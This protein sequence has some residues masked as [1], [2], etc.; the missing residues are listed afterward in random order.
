M[1]EVKKITCR[2]RAI[3]RLN[4]SFSLLCPKGRAAS[5][6][7]LII[8]NHEIFHFKEHVRSATSLSRAALINWTCP[9]RALRHGNLIINSQ[10]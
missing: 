4:D 1:D 3:V 6:E 10:T 9:G 7:L 5:D 2:Y 8:Q